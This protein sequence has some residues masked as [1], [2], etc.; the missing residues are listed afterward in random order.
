MELWNVISSGHVVYCGP[1]GILIWFQIW[2]SAD[3]IRFHAKD[4]APNILIQF[5]QLHLFR[6]LFSIY[7]RWN[8]CHSYCGGDDPPK[9]SM[10]HIRHEL[11][12]INH[13]FSKTKTIMPNKRN[14]KRQLINFLVAPIL[15]CYR[16]TI[17]AFWGFS[18]LST[19]LLT[20]F[21]TWLWGEPSFWSQFKLNIS[22]YSVLFISC[23]WNTQNVQFIVGSTRFT[24]NCSFFR[25]H[26]PPR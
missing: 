12:F 14:P 3:S 6:S 24:S 23:S 5:I 13:F 18:G 9:S 8:P 16:I 4:L 21:S 25:I 15:E 22:K 11:L 20:T 2:W 26:D 1:M 17:N 7:S 19:N 10:M